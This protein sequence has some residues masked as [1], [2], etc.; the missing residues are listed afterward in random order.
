[1]TINTPS[2]SS[3]S[4]ESSKGLGTLVQ[5]AGSGIHHAVDRARDSMAPALSQMSNGAQAVGDELQHAMNEGS[6]AAR[7]A[8]R[9][10]GDAQRHAVSSLRDGISHRPLTAISVAAG[11]GL[12]VGFLLRLR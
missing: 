10:A 3:R 9:R 1:M 7:G 8:L 11:L 12:V 2:D 5:Q 6:A 4:N